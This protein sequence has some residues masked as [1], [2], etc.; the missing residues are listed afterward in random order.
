M[1]Q[2][3]STSPFCQRTYVLA[4]KKKNE[5]N[6]HY[7]T[8]NITEKCNGGKLKRSKQSQANVIYH[9]KTSFQIL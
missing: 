1:I 9:K 4:F 8:G 7:L 2:I 3:I 6:N 5:N